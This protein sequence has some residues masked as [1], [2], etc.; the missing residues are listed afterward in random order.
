MAKAVAQT[1]VYQGQTITLEVQQKPGLTYTWELYKDSTV[2]FA[3]VSGTVPETDAS[4]VGGNT[5]HR[6]GITW[7]QAGVYF[8]KITAVHASGCTNNL[9]VGRI[10]ILEGLPA[11]RMTANSVCS[12][13]PATLTVELTGTGPWDITYTDGIHTKTV[14]GIT[15][16]TYEL[17]ISPEPTSSSQ[18][19]ITEVTDARN[20]NSTPTPPVDLIVKPKPKSSRIY[21]YNKP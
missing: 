7:H 13:D 6:V 1:D 21:P 15:D 4:F 11:A 5:G 3:T 12:G 8:Y 17:R 20:T 19:W 18:Y 9:K 16:R 14:N 2:N 10:K